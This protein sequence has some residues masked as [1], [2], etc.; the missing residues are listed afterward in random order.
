LVSELSPATPQKVKHKLTNIRTN[1][2]KIIDHDDLIKVRNMKE[3]SQTLFFNGQLLNWSRNA[4][5][6]RSSFLHNHSSYLFY[7]WELFEF[8]DLLKLTDNRLS[9]DSGATDGSLG[10]IPSVARE[11]VDAAILQ[12]LLGIGTGHTK[13]AIATTSILIFP[14]GSSTSISSLYLWCCDGLVSTIKQ[15]TWNKVVTSLYLCNLR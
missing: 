5:D 3:N 1:L 9:D 10:A 2:I 12:Y 4:V 15:A 6:C 7:M 13:P 11:N 8:Y 14:S